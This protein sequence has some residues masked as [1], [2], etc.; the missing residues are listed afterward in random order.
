M[1]NHIVMK[2]GGT[3]VGSPKTILACIAV[4]QNAKHPVAAVVVS[5]FSG[6][7]NQ[8]LEL[9]EKVGNGDGSYKEILQTISTR[10]KDAVS[11]LITDEKR[12]KGAQQ[13]VDALLLELEEITMGSFLTKEGSPKTHDSIA[14][15]GE[16]LSAMIITDV[17]AD[18]GVHAF[19]VDGRDII[20]TDHTFTHAAVDF[21]KTNAKIATYFQSKEGLGIVTG[22]IAGTEKGET[23]TLGRGG[24][25]YTASI[26]GAALG[27]A[28]IEIWTDVDGVLTADPRKVPTAFTIEKMTYQEAMEMSHFGAKV[29][30][31]PTMIPAITKHVPILIRNTFHP[32]FSGTLISDQASNGFLIKGIS[33]ISDISVVLFQGSGM[34][35]IPGFAARV[36][37]AL[38]KKEIHVILITQA[39]SEHTIC[40]A[41]AP[42]D[43]KVAKEAIEQEFAAELAEKI[44]DPLILENH[45]A[46][47]AIVGD[48][49]RKKIGIVGKLFSVLGEND[50][51]IVAIAQGSSERNISFVISK[52][53]EVKAL[54]V[55]HRAFF[56]K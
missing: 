48:K 34:I 3:S 9:A 50:V 5:A 15:F 19:F 40:F 6:V 14:A 46:I 56:G 7:T 49:M 12:K 37:T 39:S 25:D 28:A 29:I 32:Q 38:A 18:A 4:V 24:S 22:F 54:H 52:D 27:V 2:F 45:H 13:R 11:E 55:I 42:R 23:T 10:H 16:R 51:N 53:D 30:Y 36:F 35:G 26:V 20:V 8:L 43:E 31:A 33:S 44:V 1:G 21:Q 47:I 41:I 17:F